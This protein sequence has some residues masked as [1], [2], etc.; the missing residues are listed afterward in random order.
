MQRCAFLVKDSLDR[1]TDL[2]SRVLDMH[3][4]CVRCMAHREREKGRKE[5]RTSSSQS[6]I[7]LVV[8][9][10]WNVK[11]FVVGDVFDDARDDDENLMCSCERENSASYSRCRHPGPS[12]CW[13]AKP[14]RRN[15]ARLRGL[16]LSSDKR[17]RL[18]LPP[19]FL[20]S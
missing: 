1:P 14:R 3:T 4:S 15:Y 16:R 8:F 10:L 9:I 12:S 19:P 7:R 13:N 5:E 17:R 18:L 20:P 11:R 6:V 2:T